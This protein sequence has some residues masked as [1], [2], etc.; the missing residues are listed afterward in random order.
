M[1]PNLYQYF[2]RGVLLRV[3]QQRLSIIDGTYSYLFNQQDLNVETLLYTNK[4]Y[5]QMKF[6]VLNQFYFTFVKWD[7]K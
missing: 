3:K 7:S 4:T 1:Y 2:E 5:D 6:R